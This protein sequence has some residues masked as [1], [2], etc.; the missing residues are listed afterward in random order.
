[1]PQL[2][3]PQHPPPARTRS[4]SLTTPPCTEG[5]LWHLLTA[6]VKITADQLYK[7]ELAIGDSVCPAAAAPAPAPLPSRRLL[8]TNATAN[9]TTNGTTNSTANVTAAAGA[10]AGFAYPAADA[11]GCR[12]GANNGNY[13]GAMARR[14]VGA[15]TARLPACPIDDAPTPSIASRN[16]THTHLCALPI[17]L[18]Y[19]QTTAS[20]PLPPPSPAPQSRCR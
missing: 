20:V 10:A 14:A 13:R 16:T 7:F 2:L 19:Q 1:M 5:V 3:S 17:L 8:A 4:G 18:P 11:E 12:K 15:H 6:P 9:A